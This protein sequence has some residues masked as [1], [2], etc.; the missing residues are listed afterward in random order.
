MI[1]KWNGK[2]FLSEC[3]DGLRQQICQALSIMVVDNGSSDES[4]YF[5]TQQYPEIRVNALSKNSDFCASNNI[6]LK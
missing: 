4:V 5:M 2:K 6:A 1:V 3:L